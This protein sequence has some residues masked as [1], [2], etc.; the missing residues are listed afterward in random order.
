MKKIQ[1]PDD[2]GK[3]ENENERQESYTRIGRETIDMERT[4]NNY[5]IVPA[6]ETRYMEFINNRIKEVGV[7]RKLRDDAVRMATFVI[8]AK[9]D[10]FKDMPPETERKFFADCVDF[11]ARQMGKENIISAVVHKDE[12]SPH[13]HINVVPITPDNRLCAKYYFD[14]KM[15]GWQTKVYEEVGKKWNLERGK[16]GSDAK[17]VDPKAYNKVVKQATA[18]ARAENE[19][20][21]EVNADMIK[22]LDK[23]LQEISEATT[24]RDKLITERDKE[25]NYSQA[26][27]DA[28]D[29]KIARSKREMKDQIVALTVENKRLENENAILAKDNEDLFKEYQKE[30]TN[31]QKAEVAKKA[32]FAVR[33]HELEAYARTFFKA[34]GILQPFIELFSAPIPLPRNRLREIEQEVEQERQ[35]QQAQAENNRSKYYWSK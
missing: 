1:K 27:K 19:D 7:K 14:G 9:G 16:E 31:G 22:R 17:H 5:H 21:K 11:I 2:I 6:P 35:E 13:I 26:L 8:G 30:K 15:S 12:T 34:T 33:E 23:T 25:A 29:G 3:I 4:H 24:E 28:K 20:L 18:D 32:M 10:Y